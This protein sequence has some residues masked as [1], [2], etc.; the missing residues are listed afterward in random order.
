[1]QPIL[2][3]RLVERLACLQQGQTVLVIAP[4][5]SGKTTLLSQA[6]A[7]LKQ[8]N[9]AVAWLSI[10]PLADELH[11]FFIQLI[12]AM[13]RFHP[14]FA[15]DLPAWLEETGAPP[16]QELVLRLAMAFAQLGGQR[17]ALF[18]DDFHEISSSDIHQV[19]SSLL[20]HLP[21]EVSLII[22]S[23]TA[24]ALPIASLRASNQLIEL[25]WDELRF[26]RV[27]AEQFLSRS[28]I[29]MQISRFDSIYEQTEGWPVGL[30]LA[31]ISL[32]QD[33]AAM[34]TDLAGERREIADYLLD[35]VMRQLPAEMQLFL[36]QTAILD[37]L[38]APL[39]DALRG[40]TDSRE[41]LDELEQ[42]NLFTFR[43]DE[44]RHWYR[45]H[46]LFA[47][48]LQAR[49]R[50]QHPELCAP[51]F[52]AASQ[53]HEAQGAY[54]DAIEYA[55]RGEHME[56]A[57]RLLVPYG[58]RLFEAG[59]FKELR[60]SLEQL[61]EAILSQN[62]ELSILHGWS[63][64]YV[65]EFDRARSRAQVALQAAGQATDADVYCAEIAVLRGTLGV[66]QSDRPDLA[67]ITDDLVERLHHADTSVQGF[68][69]I[70]LGYA[71]RAHG[72]LEQSREHFQTSVNL[73]ELSESPLINLLAR[74]N[75]SLLAWLHGRAAES[76][77]IARTGLQVAQRRHWQDNMGAAFL[78]VQLAA[79]LYE[80]NRLE[81][82][83]DELDTA[84]ETLQATQAFGFLGVAFVT[85][86]M[87]HWASGADAK[88]QAD[89]DHAEEIA[90]SHAVERVRRRMLQL[91]IRMA[92]AAGQH[93]Q[94]RQALTQ[95]LMLLQPPEELQQ[96][97]WPEHYEAFKVLEARLLLGEG[98]WQQALELT[99]AIDA[100]AAQAQRGH[101]QVEALALSAAA[102]LAL[103]QEQAASAALQKA[104]ALA[105]PNRHWRG[106]FFTGP[107]LADLV[108]ELAASG[109]PAARELLDQ[110]SATS[111]AGS[112][113][114]QQ[115]HIRE[116]QI[117]T[118]LA[119]GLQNREIA[120]RLFLSEETIKWYLKRLYRRLDVSN[121]TAAVATARQ[122]G[123]IQE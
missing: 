19:L 103:T 61:P 18:L 47:E 5:G 73:T 113:N 90:T 56:R 74:F 114:E 105:A 42:R 96:L 100:S 43:L 123:L 101:N 63:Y 58:R 67:L 4:A 75:L 7:A 117:L 1:M 77:R 57:A 12:A 81:E 95:G 64:A 76:K 59:R 14:G 24:P 122:L 34:S 32:A 70:I 98:K 9:I 60:L 31:S 104:L 16:L 120:T 121:R 78:R 79:A 38:S 69:H 102:L 108:S 27:E 80:S 17:L 82:A 87:A 50:E 40:R 86:A 30:Q 51:L 11:R 107:A 109:N 25:G 110:L 37:R 111:N 21:D 8:Q 92:L 20:A 93:D 119:D 29:C 91:T 15:S 84:I 39:C 72:Q 2:R 65:G 10:T 45:Y 41:F 28:G 112:S 36:L 46:H 118:L 52:A 71:H 33:T 55:L 116:Q 26:S 85:R 44:N 49:L 13:R 115:L 22:G 106:F 99:Q 68:A 88:A 66:I 54:Q 48:F 97:P 62:P 53:W 89:L 23:R 3:S 94:A 35:V 83:L 6:H